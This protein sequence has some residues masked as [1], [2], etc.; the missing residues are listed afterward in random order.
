M[1]GCNDFPL[2]LNSRRPTNKQTKKGWSPTPPISGEY[3]ELRYTVVGILVSGCALFLFLVTRTA[4]AASRT[5]REGG[6]QV[7]GWRREAII[8][9]L[10]QSVYFDHG[11]PA[12][13]P[14][15]LPPP[16]PSCVTLHTQTHTHIQTHHT[17]SGIF[18]PF[19]SPQESVSCLSV[20]L[21]LS[22]CLSHTHTQ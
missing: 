2:F 14:L 19:F 16:V 21:S 10:S 13:A 15:S 17:Q 11:T 3:K 1:Y 5:G 9:R 4:Q 18:T 7:V 6:G 20:S 12:L 22:L 8:S